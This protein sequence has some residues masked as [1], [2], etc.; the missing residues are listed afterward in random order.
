LETKVLDF[1]FRMKN[2]KVTTRIQEGVTVEETN[3]RISPDILILGIDERSLARF[4]RWPFPRY[5]HAD[6]LNTFSRIRD[7][8]ERER[9]LF[10]D[11]FFNEPDEKSPQ[12]DAAVVAAIRENGRVFLET[13]LQREE[14]PEIE[15]AG[16]FDRQAILAD[17]FGGITHLK[18]DWTKVDSFYGIK[19]PLLPYTEATYGY[20]H[21]N[22]VQDDDQVYR[23][24]S[25]ISRASRLVEE[26][27]LESLTVDTPVDPAAFER[28]SWRDTHNV[29]HDVS[30]PLTADGIEDLREEMARSAPPASEEDQDGDGKIDKVT[31]LVRKY[32]ETWLPSVT[33]ALAV[34]YVHARLAD[35]EV[36]VGTHVR[37]PSPQRFNIETKAWEPYSIVTRATTLD[38]ATGEVVKP[39]VRKALTEILIPI[40][41]HGEMLIN[42]M[43]YPSSA[44]FGASS[45]YPIRSYSRYASSPPG[46]DPQTWDDTLGMANKIVMLGAF[47][48]GMAEDQKPTPF[49]L[50]FGVE[51]HANALNTILMGNFLRYTPF[52][53]SILII[54]GVVMLTAFMTSRLSTVWSLVVLVLVLAAYFGA[55]LVLF[56]FYAYILTLSAPL[57]GAFLSFLGVVAYRTVFEE[58]DKRRNKAIF[59]KIVGPAVLDQI[60]EHPPE[61]GGQDKELTVF[62]SDIRSFSSIS[63]KMTSQELVNYLNKYFTVMTEIIKDYSG[64]L[65]KLIGDAVMGF[66]GA[67]VPQADHALLACKCA[68]KQMEQ[69][70]VLN[71]SWEEHERID[72]GIGISTGIMTAAYMGSSDR[73]NYTV[74]GDAVNLGSR[75][76]GLNKMYY[77]TAK[78]AGHLSRIIISENTYEQVKDK[79]IAREL[80]VVRVK[81]KLAPA[82][83]YELIDVE[84]GFEPPKPPASKGKMLAAES[85]ADRKARTAAA[86][87]GVKGRGAG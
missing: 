41:E 35:V 66:W 40:D 19:P 68:L 86:K 2:P 5:R 74:I 6:L 69:L 78:G 42:F 65:D 31:Y 58:R 55:V 23:R 59:S 46:S 84:G 25:L 26:I 9:A 16:P 51:I 45:T 50:M 77:D 81:G 56:D 10:L 36:V 60:L 54:F 11:I 37:I 44:S 47:S 12:D 43:G 87:A 63:E 28:L 21:A 27:P 79:V 7:Q 64:T 85:K 32:K 15:G 13:V 20:G 22:Y 70:A 14:F 67:P 75:L 8:E 73:L 33:L 53:L 76:E 80:D 62:F 71:A 17:R 34:E 38:P 48:Q 29:E 61:L 82:V 3:P 24:A 39:E 49:G 4:G 1:N 57:F 30:V 18:G 72:I 52:W 83:I